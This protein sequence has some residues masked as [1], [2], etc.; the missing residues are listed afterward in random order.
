MAYQKPS[1]DHPWRAWL[2][3]PE[4][5][6]N[7]RGNKEQVSKQENIK[8]VRVFITEIVESW[9]EVEVVTSAYGKEGK[10]TLKSLPQKKQA[11]W[12]ASLLRRSYGRQS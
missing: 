7:S 4:K 3:D 2:G 6:R 1:E 12:L 10:Y 8:P 11:S 9:D 5:D